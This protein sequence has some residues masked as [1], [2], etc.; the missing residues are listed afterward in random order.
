V[1]NA[2]FT[3][4]QKSHLQ[5]LSQVVSVSNEAITKKRNKEL[6]LK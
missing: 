5:A 3:S 1:N 6:Q 2:I 4:Y